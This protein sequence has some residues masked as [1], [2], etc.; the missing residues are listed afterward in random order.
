MKSKGKNSYLPIDISTTLLT[1][2]V[3]P[4]FKAKA[5]AMAKKNLAPLLGRHCHSGFTTF[6]LEKQAISIVHS[7]TGL[8]ALAVTSGTSWAEMDISSSA[9]VCV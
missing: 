7:L 2:N 5:Q 9:T 4:I 1:R 3:K 8:S 6:L